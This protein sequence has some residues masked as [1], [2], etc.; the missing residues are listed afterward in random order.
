LTFDGTTLSV[1]TLNEFS[2]LKYK[3]DITP[4]PEPL[5]GV[6]GMQG[7]YFT[8]KEDNTRQ[9]GFIADEIFETYPELVKLKDGEVDGLQYQRITAVLVEAMKELSDK[10]DSQ[11]KLIKDLISRI[12]KLESK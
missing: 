7:V 11:E 8:R 5:K 6:R 12:T 10:V 4:I 3:K 2:A 1:N 9:I